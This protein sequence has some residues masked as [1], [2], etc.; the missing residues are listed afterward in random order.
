MDVI[1]TVG[2]RKSYGAKEVLHGIDL[3]IA[4]GKLIGFLGPN[5][6]GKTTAIRILLGLIRGTK[7]QARVLG[8]DAWRD[9]KR[10]RR[11]VGYLPGEARFYGNLT[12]AATLSFLSS[13][14]RIDCR[15]EI[16]RLSRAFDLDLQ[17]KVRKY[18]SGMKQKLG[19]IAAMMHRPRLLVLDEPTNGLDPLVR[20]SVFVE[21]RT[22]VDDGHSVLFSSHTL[23]EVEELSQE[24]IILRDGRVIEHAQVEVLRRQ[25]LR[26]VM[27]EFAS[28]SSIPLQWPP[29]LTVAH[30]NGR[31]LQATWTGDMSALLHWLGKQSIAD[32]TIEQP[33]LEDLF[34]SYYTTDLASRPG[35]K[36]NVENAIED[37]S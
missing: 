34:L 35:E 29:G 37:R 27:I 17:K 30:Q 19:I 25:A 21:L 6:A 36:A 16:D 15:K 20:K 10:I 3:S 1:Q 5:G 7:G 9:G 13:A 24:V 33:N 11:D 8:H 4:E 2:L 12:G 26:R 32:V 22:F 14:R 31:Q 18:S 28:E 23:R